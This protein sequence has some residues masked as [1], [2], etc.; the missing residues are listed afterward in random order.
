MTMQAYGIEEGIKVQMLPIDTVGLS[1]FEKYRAWLCNQR[2]V[3]VLEA[4]H[5]PRPNGG[6]Y[7]L[8]A[9]FEFDGG[10]VPRW[11][12]LLIILVEFFHPISGWYP[13]EVFWWIDK[14][15]MAMVIIGLA[16]ERFGLM[17]YAFGVHDFA[18]RYG[19]LITGNSRVE[20]IPS[21][22]V[23]NNAM[24]RVNFATNDMI[25]LGWVAHLAVVSGAWH[26][27]R[28]HRK[29]RSEPDLSWK[30]LDYGNDIVIV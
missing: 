15:F 7:V 28:R 18:V 29:G 8:P 10:S 26:A 11:L 6:S 3:R 22:G 16:I 23:A 13:H 24:R 4:F 30:T 1:V 12:L 2:R 17:L 14:A 19:V 9:G 25:L 20:S 5:V 21:I 27:W